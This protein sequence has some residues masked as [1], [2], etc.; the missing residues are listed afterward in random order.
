MLEQ[1]IKK[2]ESRLAEIERELSS[3]PRE[4]SRLQ[5]LMEDGYVRFATA[6]KAVMDNLRIAARNIFYQSLSPFRARYDNY[7][8]DHELYRRLSRSVGF[9]ARSG[10][11]ITVT[12]YPNM[13]LGE[14]LRGHFDQE[15]AAVSAA[16][17]NR[18]RALP[19]HPI[20][21][22]WLKLRPAPE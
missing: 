11:T 16:L 20:R 19:D 17:T 9:I 7:R 22:V 15:L 8:D 12:L 13:E 3:I 6:R 5:A 18:V 10:S 4:E 21:R 2:L 14:T 1:Q